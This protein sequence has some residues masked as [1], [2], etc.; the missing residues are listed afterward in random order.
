MVDAAT[1]VVDATTEQLPPGD[2]QV[3][4]AIVA[5]HFYENGVHVNEYT[6][7]TFSVSDNCRY[8]EVAKWYAYSNPDEIYYMPG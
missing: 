7:F 3:Y 2:Y 1:I 6:I 4:E 8:H 5:S